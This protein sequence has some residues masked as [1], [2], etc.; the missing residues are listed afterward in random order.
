MV[1]ETKLGLGDR[2]KQYYESPTNI[3]LVRRM[4]VIIRLDG[5]AFH[6]F[7]RGCDKPFDS[8]LSDNMIDTA[9]YLCGEIQGAK[10]AY[11]Q[12]DEISILL[13]DFDTLTTGAWFDNNLQKIVSVSA[14]MASAH[15]SK[16][17]EAFAVFDCRAFNI[18]KE[19]V[20]NYFVWRQ[21]DWTR[22]SVQMLARSHFSH[23]Q[24][25]GKGQTEMHE[26]LHFIGINWAELEPRWRNGTVVYKEANEDGGWYHTSNIRFTQQRDFIESYLIPKEE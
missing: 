6:T 25:L 26:M 4:P 15:F 12:S 17:C 16:L 3:K 2:M 23:K 11:V 18:P 21:K 22:N 20:C 9:S 13:T 14:G 10:C 24:L 1:N 7:T 8:K 5:R 19:E